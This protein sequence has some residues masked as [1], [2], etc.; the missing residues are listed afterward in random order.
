M[1]RFDARREPDDA[2]RVEGEVE[3]ACRPGRHEH[4]VVP[5]NMVD[6]NAPFLDG[7]HDVADDDD[8]PDEQR[9]TRFGQRR[10]EQRHADAIDR[11]R[12]HQNRD[13]DLR[14]AFPDA[15]VGLAIVFA[16]DF[17]DISLGAFGFRLAFGLRRRRGSR[18]RR[19]ARSARAALEHVLERHAVRF[20]RSRCSSVCSLDGFLRGIGCFGRIDHVD[21]GGHVNAVC[22]LVDEGDITF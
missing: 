3:E 20:G 1:K 16:H 12:S 6:A 11:E 10:A 2:H 22:G 13:D 7:I 4:D 17:V 21:R 15:R 9:Q 5:W 8:E 18:P 14:F 19:L